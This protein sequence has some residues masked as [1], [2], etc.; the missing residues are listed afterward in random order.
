MARKV[1]AEGI[2]TV[3]V[4]T[5][6]DR[7]EDTANIHDILLNSKLVNG[8]IGVITEPFSDIMNAESKF[9]LKNKKYS[10]LE[11]SFGIN[12]LLDSIERQYRAQ[13]SKCLPIY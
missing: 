2:R 6:F 4:I 13:I 9:F 10:E 1:D 5:K 8:F 12:F 3:P 7:I 11:G